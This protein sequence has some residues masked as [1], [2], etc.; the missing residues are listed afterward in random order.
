MIKDPQNKTPVPRAMKGSTEHILIQQH[1][2]LPALEIYFISI[3]LTQCEN[4]KSL[5]HVHDEQTTHTGQ[6]ENKVD[7][8]RNAV[9]STSDYESTGLSSIPDEGRRRTA[10]PAVHPPKRVGR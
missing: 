10:H 8:Y 5:Q 7:G 2:A 6:R 4:N 1:T 3:F 9:V